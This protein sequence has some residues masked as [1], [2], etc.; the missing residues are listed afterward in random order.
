MKEKGREKRDENPPDPPKSSFHHSNSFSP[1]TEE[2]QLNR[3]M[4]ELNDGGEGNLAQ[5]AT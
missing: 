1:S 5:F 3:A 2:E 4:D